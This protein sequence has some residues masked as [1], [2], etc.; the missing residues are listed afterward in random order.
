MSKKEKL[1]YEVQVEPD[2]E[3]S[4]SVR[5]GDAQDG[6]HN[7]FGNCPHTTDPINDKVEWES[8]LGTGNEIKG[9]KLYVSSVTIDSNPNTNNVSVRVKINGEEIMPTSGNRVLTVEEKD[10][11][12]FNQKLS[13]I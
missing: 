6:D 1:V 7:V 12:Y 5:I 13:F 8:F 4:I 9:K 2:R 3:Y 11:A 10:I